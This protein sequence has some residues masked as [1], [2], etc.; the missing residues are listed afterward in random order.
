MS[1]R[2]RVVPDPDER[3]DIEQVLAQVTATLV[4]IDNTLEAVVEAIDLLSDRV[5][6]LERN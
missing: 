4:A 3:S 6:R 5:E 1:D 2:L